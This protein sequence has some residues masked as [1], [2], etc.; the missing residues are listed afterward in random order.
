MLFQRKI[1]QRWFFTRLYESKVGIK[2]VMP[3]YIPEFKKEGSLFC[4]NA[5][6]LFLDFDALRDEY[7]LCDASVLESPHLGLMNALDNDQDIS[8]IEYIKRWENGT[9]DYRTPHYVT[10][11][12]LEGL[13]HRFHKSKEEVLSDLYPAVAVY[14]LGG[15]YYIADGKHRAAMCAMLGKPV[16]CM[17]VG[18][19]YVADSFNQWM[20][21]RMSL[22]PNKY[23]KNLLFFEQLS[24]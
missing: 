23:R 22:K 16:K 17:L 18:N 20:Y 5:D 4:A 8:D 15:R 2:Y 21:K 6:E 9:L 1:A 13:R 10:K 7:T 19:K 3:V 14:K 24:D 12:E 11:S